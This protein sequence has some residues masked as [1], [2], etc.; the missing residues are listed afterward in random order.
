MIQQLIS[1]TK[2]D[3]INHLLAEHCHWLCL[4]RTAERALNQKTEQFLIEWHK[5]FHEEA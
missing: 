2:Q 3:L 5:K 4:Q 1:K